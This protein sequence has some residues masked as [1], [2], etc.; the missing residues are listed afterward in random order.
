[1]AHPDYGED[2]KRRY[3]YMLGVAYR[4]KGLLG[5]AAEDVVGEAILSLLQ[6]YGPDP[7]THKPLGQTGAITV[8]HRADDIFDHQEFVRK[9]EGRYAHE[10]QTAIRNGFHNTPSPEGELVEGEVESTWQQLRA[11]VLAGSPEHRVGLDGDLLDMMFEEAEP[12]GHAAI[13]PVLLRHPDVPF[14][15]AKTR[16]L[17]L[18]RRLKEQWAKMQGISPWRAL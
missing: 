2:F 12:T 10:I 18:R 8:R 13:D 6:R 1:M 14:N 3:D 7:A 15:T 16:V 17:K 5:P 11:A 9:T 4:S